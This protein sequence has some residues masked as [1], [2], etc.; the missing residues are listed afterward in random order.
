MRPQDKHNPGGKVKTKLPDTIVGSAVFSECGRYRW[1]LTRDWTPKGETARTIMFCGM[2]PS[3][4]DAEASDPTITRETVF[5]MDWG[6][7]RLLKVNVLDWRATKPADLP[8]NA[9]DACSPENLKEISRMTA[10][11]GEIILAYGRMHKRFHPAVEQVI[12]ICRESR[13][14][15]FCL[16]KNADGSAKHP[17]YLAKT[18]PR[19]PF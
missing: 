6:F 16:G 11:A 17:L 13:K 9:Q 18:T 19:T 12:E 3:T 15:L 8:E 2:N 10:Q 14:P 1:S 7:T 5:A 4:A